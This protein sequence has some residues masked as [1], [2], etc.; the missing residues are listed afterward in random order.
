LF[1][2][3]RPGG[4]HYATGMK[5]GRCVTT[6]L[7]LGLFGTVGLFGG[8]DGHTTDNDII[9]TPI[10]ELRKQ[11]ETSKPGQV[12]LIDARSPH[13]YAAGHIPDARN[14]PLDTFSGKPADR[15]PGIEAFEYKVV[16][17]NDPGSAV[18]K[19]VTKRM[20][21]QG[22]SGVTMF[23]GGLNEWRRAGMDVKGEAAGKP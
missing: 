15:D 20:L 6:A 12:L 5:S 4:G 2:A 22:Y 19:G 16:Y 11:V 23:M 3:C 13:E 10:A 8:C 14:M 1:G 9:D 21:I 7:T 17:G 18:A